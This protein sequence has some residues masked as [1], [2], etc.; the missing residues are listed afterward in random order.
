MA[1]STDVVNSVNGGAAGATGTRKDDS[2]QAIQDR[3]LKLLVAQLNN[4][5]PMNPLDNAQMTSQIAQLNTVTG[6]ENLNSTVSS[7]LSQVASMQAMQG[8]S[9]IGREV[10]VPGS[11]LTV[12]D[13]T[14]R[15]A[16]ELSTPADSVKVQVKTAGGM[17][18][19]TVDLGAH[20]A[21]R[22]NFEWDASKY[23]GGEALTFTV[24]ATAG[25]QALTSVALQRARVQ[26][27]STDNNTLM[28]QL[29][30]REPVAYSNVKAIL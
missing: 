19:D 10:L 16:F 20:K 29:A 14:G 22:H 17:L 2:A 8:A 4:Q 27:V 28:L 11:G 23:T 30:G 7:V 18:V 26:S 25:N 5:D 3:F 6:I 12:A 21:G 24:Q 13:G 1:I 15:G 9:M